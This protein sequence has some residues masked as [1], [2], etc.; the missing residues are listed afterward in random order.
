ML[1]VFRLTAEI[2]KLLNA[3]EESGESPL[4]KATKGRHLG[5]ARHLLQEGAEKDS[6]DSKGC[7]PLCI[8]ASGSS[9]D[10]L[11][12][13]LVEA[14]ANPDIQSTCKL[15]YTPLTMAAN[16]GEVAVVDALLRRGA[17]PKFTAGGRRTPL[18]AA[19]TAG[20]LGVVDRLLEALKGAGLGPA[21]EEGEYRGVVGGGGGC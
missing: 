6:R 4:H 21:T 11:N 5:L 7:T 15:A 12:L 20:H 19:A 2:S 1:L 8:A 16:V 9:M 3:E 18:F 10:L 13:F 17:N 14:R